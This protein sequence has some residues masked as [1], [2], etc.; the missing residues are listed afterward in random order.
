MYLRKWE[1]KSELKVKK[2]GY[3]KRIENLEEKLK[4]SSW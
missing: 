1:P 3:K 2:R 4:D